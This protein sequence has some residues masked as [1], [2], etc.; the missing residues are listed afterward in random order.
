MNAKEAKNR[1]DSLNN[2]GIQFET[3][4]IFKEIE[5]L[6]ALG[7]YSYKISDLSTGVQTR[8]KDLGYKID[9]FFDQRENISNFTIRWD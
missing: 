8:L 4:K 1:A 6:A 2:I 7:Y 9:Y 5:R 3:R